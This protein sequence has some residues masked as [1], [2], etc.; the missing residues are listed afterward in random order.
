MYIEQARFGTSQIQKP[1]AG[2]ETWNLQRRAD[3][4]M[5]SDS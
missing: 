1:I 3:S 4:S 5:Q 2:R